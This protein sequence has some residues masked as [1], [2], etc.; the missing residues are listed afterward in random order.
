[1]SSRLIYFAYGSNLHPVRLCERVPSDRLSTTGWL[2][3]Y[4]LAFHKRGQD[5]SGKCNLFYTG[6][7]SDYVL[8]AIY[9]LDREHKADLDRFEGRGNGYIDQQLEIETTSGTRNC[10]SYIAEQGHIDDRL[11]PYHWYKHLVGEGARFLQF[12]ASYVRTIDEIGSHPDPHR[13]RDR[14]HRALIERMKKYRGAT[15]TA[16]DRPG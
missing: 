1:M 9:T 6:Q 2:N 13:Q 12:H 15:V 3:R 14:E 16:I 10:F 11:L 7:T 5:G 4:R 8:G